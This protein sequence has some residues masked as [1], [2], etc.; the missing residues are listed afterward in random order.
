MEQFASIK[1]PTSHNPTCADLLTM[2]EHELAAFLGAVTELFGSHQAQV[3]AEDW[4]H[5]LMITNAL[6]ASAREWRLLTVKVV[7]QLAQRI[8][9]ADEAASGLRSNT[10]EMTA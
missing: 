2:A 5:E 6:P 1:W 3:S 8:K 4:F 9:A 7:T 10:L